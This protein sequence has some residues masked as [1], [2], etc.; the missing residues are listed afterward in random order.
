MPT[1]QLQYVVP[2]EGMPKLGKPGEKGDL[3]VKF[4]IVFPEQIASD[5]RAA[6]IALLE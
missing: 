5:K 6:L 3:T 2:G 1:P 4:N